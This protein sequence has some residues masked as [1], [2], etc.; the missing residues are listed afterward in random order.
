[1]L[2]E[3]NIQV[4]QGLPEKWVDGQP[5]PLPKVV[6]ID[7]D[8]PKGRSSWL[9]GQPWELKHHVIRDLIHV[10]ISSNFHSFILVGCL[11]TSNLKNGLVTFS[12]PR[13][14]SPLS[15]LVPLPQARPLFA[16]ALVRSPLL[17]S[18]GWLVSV[19]MFCA[20]E[21][22]SWSACD[23]WVVGGLVEQDPSSTSGRLPWRCFKGFRSLAMKLTIW[24]RC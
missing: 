24:K 12:P 22:A 11:S 14:T 18:T 10:P 19:G 5:K 21:E 9:V 8:V 16:C 2:R 1:M 13:T 7:D 3:A 6:P 20:L 17:D 15:S 23:G 4:E